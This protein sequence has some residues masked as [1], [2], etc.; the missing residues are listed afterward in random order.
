MRHSVCGRKNKV[1][2]N[3]R[4]FAEVRV[5]GDGIIHAAHVANRTSALAAPF[6]N[7][8]VKYILSFIFI[9]VYI[10]FGHEIGF[11]TNSPWW[12]H[13]TYTFQHASILHLVINTLVFIN[14]FRV[15]EKFLSWKVLLPAIYFI[16]TCASFASVQSIPTVGAS[17][18]IY[19]MFGMMSFIVLFNS[20]TW[21]QK[22]VFYLSILFMLCVS[23]FNKNSNFMVHVASCILGFLSYFSIK[24]AHPN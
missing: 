5:R 11:V 9:L 7:M 12:T 4:T 18:M 22:K 16:A 24:K 6:F 10:F 23:Y 8:A 15:M 20:S 13:F 21:K 1:K 2:R 17:G 19:A 14:V 3:R